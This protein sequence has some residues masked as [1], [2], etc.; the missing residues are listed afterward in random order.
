M[1]SKNVCTKHKKVPTSRIPTK[2]QN[3][4]S[5]VVFIGVVLF[6][7]FLCFP[8]LLIAC[9]VYCGCTTVVQFLRKNVRKYRYARESNIEYFIW[10][11]LS[12]GTGMHCMNQPSRVVSGD[13]TV[14]MRG[15][16]GGG[17]RERVPTK[18]TFNLWVTI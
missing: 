14:R 18:R 2:N 6:F 1:L 4:I 13:R 12:S 9:N 8:L 16:R 17:G 11:E 3:L 7:W 5:T 10:P 15:G